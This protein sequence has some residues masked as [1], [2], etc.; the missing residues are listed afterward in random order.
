MN[1]I[2]NWISKNRLIFNCILLAILFCFNCFAEEGAYLVYPLLAIFMFTESRKDALSLLIFSIPFICLSMPISIYMYFAC[3]ILYEIKSYIVAYCIDKKKPSKTLLIVL[4]VFVGFCLL[5]IGEY[6]VNLIVKLCCIL[7]IVSVVT[8]F[9]KYPDDFR[10]KYNLRLLSVSLLISSAYSL[11]YFVSPYL[12]SIFAFNSSGATII[13]F[14][15]LFN[16][17]NELAMLC[18]VCLALL[19]YLT[20]RK[21]TVFA[22]IIPFI[23]FSI[24]G[25]TTISKTFIILYG[26][27]MIVLLVH[28][29]RLYPFKTLLC[30]T[31]GAFLVMCIV[32]MKSDFVVKY[33]N[34]FINEDVFTAEWSEK[35]SYIT[36]GRY[37]LWV[38]MITYIGQNPQIILFGAGLG[39]EKVS[40]ESPHNFFITALYNFGIIGLILFVALF[41]VLVANMRKQGIKLGGAI[42]VPIVIL[43]MLFLAEDFFLYI[44]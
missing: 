27:M 42:A 3:V 39:G 44:R 28:C 34:R 6:N 16:N 13:R 37:D 15:A 7:T 38:D 18:E 2:K 24:V 43:C 36:T 33:A 23:I 22:D 20:L 11:L 17:I 35:L 19:V 9:T 8:L 30:V 41:A 32:I 12:R 25:L 14:P 31:V 5:P 4:G 40:I 10:L 1:K 21:A 29:F 26:V